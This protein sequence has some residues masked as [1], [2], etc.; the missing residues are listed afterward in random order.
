MSRLIV[1]A[2]SYRLKFCYI[3]SKSYSAD[4]LI[5]LHSLVIVSFVYLQTLNVW[6]Y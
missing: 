3:L 1:L 6:L 4:T 2:D 5:I